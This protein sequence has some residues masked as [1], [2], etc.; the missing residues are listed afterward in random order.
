MY[1]ILG[2]KVI[3]VDGSQDMTDRQLGAWGTATGDYVGAYLGALIGGVL[4]I[5]RSL[6]TWDDCL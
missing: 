6:D 4:W 2:M 1:D 5:G 3:A